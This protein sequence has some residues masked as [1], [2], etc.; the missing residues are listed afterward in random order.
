MYYIIFILHNWIF[1][2][3]PYNYSGKDLEST[4]FIHISKK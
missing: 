2:F 3:I 1:G 4:V